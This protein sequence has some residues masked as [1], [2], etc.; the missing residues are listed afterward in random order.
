[1]PLAAADAGRTAIDKRPVAGTVTAR[2]LG[3]DGD[4]QIDKPAHGGADKAVYA[5][6]LE[7]LRDW[8]ALLDRDLRPGQFG[9]NLTTLGVDLI[10]AVVGERWQVGDAVLEVSTPRIPCKTFAWF[11]G[12]SRWVKR[13]TDYGAPGAYL[14]VVVEGGLGKGDT[15][16]VVDRPAHGLTIGE[17]FRALTGDRTLAARLLEAPELPEWARE[18]ARKWLGVEPA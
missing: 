4:Q 10:G 11:L 13:F 16:T 6:A 18:R 17:T 7:D 15:I 8:A 14:R 3:L 9:E 2:A 1:M 12:E 5:Y